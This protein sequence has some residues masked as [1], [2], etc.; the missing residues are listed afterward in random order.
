[1]IPGASLRGADATPARV[2]R[3]ANASGRE[4][5]NRIAAGVSAGQPRARSRAE[6]A[7]RVA[8]PQPDDALSAQRAADHHPLDRLLLDGVPSGALADVR[9]AC[10]RRVPESGAIDERVVEDQVGGAEPVDGAQREQVGI[11]GPGA[12]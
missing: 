9:P 3:Q 4:A 6:V 11:A 12:D 2:P 1:M 7:A 8:I 5:E 10:L